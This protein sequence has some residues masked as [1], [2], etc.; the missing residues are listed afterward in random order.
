MKIRH[1][2]S[3]PALLL[4]SAA[5]LADEQSITLSV[6]GM[7]C[8]S[9]PYMI[10]QS[11]MFVDGVQTATADLKSRTCSVVYDDAIASV[12]DILGATADIGYKSTVIEPGN[13]S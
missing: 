4:I 10:E 7:D 2:L 5:S 3:L 8:P 11:V 6:P 12:E 9:C 13:G 1:L